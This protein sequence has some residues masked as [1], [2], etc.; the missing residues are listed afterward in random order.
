[1]LPR[2]AA[3]MAACLQ[4]KCTWCKD[5]TCSTDWQVWLNKSHC[6]N[7]KSSQAACSKSVLE[8]WNEGAEVE[9]TL[10]KSG[11]GAAWTDAGG[12]KEE[13]GNIRRGEDASF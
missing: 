3:C 10:S 7:V 11:A 12:E 2:M 5:T 6:I 4:S 9:R 13:K 1:M 8:L